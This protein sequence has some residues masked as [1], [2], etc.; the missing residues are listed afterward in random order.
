MLN[1]FARRLGVV[2]LLCVPLIAAAIEPGEY[3]TEK[4]WGTLVVKRDK[5]GKLLFNIESVGDN[6]H[7][8]SL[9]G[10]IKQGKATLE[11]DEP[12]EPCVVTFTQ[13]RSGI[14]VDRNEGMACQFYCGVR[15][16]FDGVYM[17][18]PA[19]CRI[20]A[21][22]KTRAAARKA[23]DGK[24]YDA[25]RN[26]LGTTLKDCK[27]F[28]GTFTEA[29]LRNDLAVT[30]HKLK[31]LPGCREALKPLAE[32]AAQKDAKIREDYAPLEADIY[33]RIL[34]AT[35]VNLKLC[36]AAKS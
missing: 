4:S 14:K 24:N 18:A 16:S 6:G 5:A 33:V 23:Y 32:D 28:L 12:K 1:H 35:R 17:K 7:S 8:C 3:I 30:L 25:A 15:A 11:G 36:A 19:A 26:L 9:E 29:W 2:T 27:T 21:V 22:E 13:G 31:D 20:D 10:E 34:K